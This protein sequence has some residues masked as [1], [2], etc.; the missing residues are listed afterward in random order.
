MRK[1]IHSCLFLFIFIFGL[2]AQQWKTI[3]KS[4][5]Y[6][7]LP[8]NQFIINQNKNQLWFVQDINVSVINSNGSIQLFG[9]NELGDLWGG[10]Y[11][12]FVF[13]NSEI[14]YKKDYFGLYNF[15]NYIGEMLT[16]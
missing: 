2:K 9:E 13:T 12:E 4:D 7:Y 14:F 16:I 6:L 1:L 5:T 11:L 8:S 10:S 3:L 15:S